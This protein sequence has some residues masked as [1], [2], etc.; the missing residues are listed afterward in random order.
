[1]DSILLSLS[2]FLSFRTFVLF[3]TLPRACSIH[4][5]EYFSGCL[6]FSF[7]ILVIGVF[8]RE[9]ENG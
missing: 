6:D 1:M 9:R 2:L 8:F 5:M 3:H 7:D 4:E